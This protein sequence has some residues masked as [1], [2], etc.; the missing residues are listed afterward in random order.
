MAGVA[1]GVAVVGPAFG[2]VAVDGV[3]VAGALLDDADDLV[4]VDGAVVTGGA[5]AGSSQGVDQSGS[6]GSVAVIGNEW[7]CSA[8]AGGSSAA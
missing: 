7:R 1:A 3:A 2:V 6:K 4:A 5:A 8:L